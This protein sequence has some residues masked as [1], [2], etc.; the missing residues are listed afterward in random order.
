MRD[1]LQPVVD[2]LYDSRKLIRVLPNLRPGCGGRYIDYD[3]GWTI[4]G[5][6]AGGVE[7]FRAR[8]DRLRGPPSLPHNV[9]F[10][11]LRG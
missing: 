9:F 2:P 5:S 11:S 7:I 4:R 8:P 1:P 3:T 6:N 10:F